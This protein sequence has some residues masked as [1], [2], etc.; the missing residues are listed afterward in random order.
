MS[1]RLLV[2]A[3]FVVLATA[4]AATGCG[5]PSGDEGGPHV[6]VR[7]A[8]ARAISGA[9]VATP[10]APFP[11]PVACK[12]DTDC[13]ASAAASPTVSICEANRCTSQTR[14]ALFDWAKQLPEIAA[15]REAP[16]FDDIV[17]AREERVPLHVDARTFWP[18]APKK[19]VEIVFARS[20]TTL[21]AD[22]PERFGVAPGTRDEWF[23]TILLD[24]AAMRRGSFRETTDPD[25]SVGT[26]AEGGFNMLGHRLAGS[27]EEGLSY[28][29]LP[30]EASVDCATTI[31]DQP[32]C[33]PARCTHCNRLLVVAQLLEPGAFTATSPPLVTSRG[34][35]CV[36]CTDDPLILQLPRI[37]LALEGRTFVEVTDEGPTF[38]RQRAAC[39]RSLM[40]PA[41]R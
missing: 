1:A 16:S 39:T 14:D 27:T 2:L 30:Y 35:P 18:R 32:S 26:I 7:R 25:G 29:G 8:G 12:V 9:P 34:G 19:C 22:I 6:A 17:W 40:A 13:P 36:A 24:D 41:K 31:I 11:A 10:P 3:V 33:T 23:T 38:H 15:L 37:N 5:A 4:G 21:V 28:R 20:G